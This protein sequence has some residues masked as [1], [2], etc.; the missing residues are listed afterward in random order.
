M[1]TRT[2]ATRI[3]SRI[4]IIALVAVSAAFFAGCGKKAEGDKGET[5]AADKGEKELKAA[6]D[7]IKAQK[8]EDAA[9]SFQAAADKGNSDA[10][11][12]LSL[13]YW[14]GKG[15]NESDEKAEAFMQK[16][17]DAGNVKAKALLAFKQI[18]DEKISK[19]DAMKQIKALEPELLKLAKADDG[20]AQ[21]LCALFCIAKIEDVE[22][23]EEMSEIMKEAQGWIEKARK[24]GSVLADEDDDDEDGDDGFDDEDDFD[25]EDE[26]D[27]DDE[28]EETSYQGVIEVEED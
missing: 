9:K 25:D 21:A 15:V 26:D 7:A 23:A 6:Q 19:E 12:Q 28:W 3:L 27:E 24:N 2:P 8:F 4:T 22:S 18:D 14:K 16:S 1:K 5:K 20:D 11:F 10:M 17:A 13:L